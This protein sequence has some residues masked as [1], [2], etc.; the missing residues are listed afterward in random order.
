M[1]EKGV[2][3]KKKEREKEK[4]LA[5]KLVRFPTCSGINRAHYEKQMVK[6]WLTN[7]RLAHK[8]SISRCS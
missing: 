5:A 1:K 3:R 4:P 6:C 7:V 2:W 8:N